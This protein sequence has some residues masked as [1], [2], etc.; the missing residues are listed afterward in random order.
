[1]IEREGKQTDVSVMCAQKKQMDVNIEEGKYCI[2]QYSERGYDREKNEGHYLS[3][4]QK[5][6]KQIISYVRGSLLISFFGNMHAHVYIK[7]PRK[8]SK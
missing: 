6:T 3:Q 8:K 2:H 7:A 1:M 4:M 5:V